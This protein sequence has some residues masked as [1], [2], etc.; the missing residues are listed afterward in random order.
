M[1]ELLE[2]K[3]AG[4]KEKIS[5]VCVTGGTLLGVVI[6]SCMSGGLCCVIT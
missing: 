5:H 1:C 6:R 3:Q 4:I 2:L